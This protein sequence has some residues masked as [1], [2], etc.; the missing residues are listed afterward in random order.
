MELWPR[1]K[2]HRWPTYGV[3][4]INITEIWKVLTS[5]INYGRWPN[6]RGGHTEI[7]HFLIIVINCGRWP[8]YRGGQLQALLCTRLVV[9]WCNT[10]SE[11]TMPDYSV[12]QHVGN[13]IYWTRDEIAMICLR[14]P[15]QNLLVSQKRLSGT[16]HR[17]GFEQSSSWI[18]ISGNTAMII[19]CR[20]AI[21]T[22][23]AARAYDAEL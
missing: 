4:S 2:T 23:R 3:M 20:L 1:C 18:R 21:Q 13:F 8:N 12:Y 7:W 10:T 11:G 15:F 14:V 22:N 9:S 19:A 5:A 6:Y 16:C 17:L